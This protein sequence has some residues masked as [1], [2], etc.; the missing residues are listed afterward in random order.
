M[1]KLVTLL[2][3]VFCFNLN[4]QTN[5][6]GGIY[7]ST[8]WSLTNSPYIVTDTVVVYPGAILT[9][10]PG[11][12]VKFNQNKQL[13]VR[14]GL[15]ANGTINNQITFTSNSVSPTAGNWP[16]IFFN[17]ALS[18]M[19]IINYCNIQYAN[20]GIRLYIDTLKIRNSKFSN[21]INGTAGSLGVSLIIDSCEFIYNTNG[22]GVSF[23]Q[24]TRVRIYNS[25]ISKNAIGINNSWY[26]TA[27]NCKLDSNTTY[28]IA[29]EDVDSLINCEINYNAI[30]IYDNSCNCFYKENRIEYNNIGIDMIST[31]S[32]YKCNKICNN[33]SYNLKVEST[34]NKNMA[35]NYWCSTNTAIIESKIYDGYDNSSLGIATISPIDTLQCYLLTGIPTF[36][37]QNPTIQIY[38]NP[39]Q[40]NFTIETNTSDK[41]TISV[42]DVNGKL[43][44]LQS[45]NATTNIDASN[46]SQGVYNVSV[47]SNEGLANKRLVIVK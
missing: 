44:L 1:K 15:H 33:T 17:Q 5:V 39:A 9:I 12:V 8:T 41:Q 18:F 26:T 20:T 16:G 19:S 31:C 24:D 25:V 11:V 4:A 34:Q 21:N 37:L 27:V 6:S 22:I 30:G 32:S 2:V 36:N 7:T 42:F 40:N 14:G 45:I 10:E 29:E 13:T 43:V 23:Y 3:I 46:L 35:N 38:P 47:T 28:A